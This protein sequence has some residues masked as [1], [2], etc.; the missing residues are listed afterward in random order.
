MDE[1]IRLDQRFQGF[2]DGALGGY[3]AGVVAKRI[4]GPAEVNLRSLPP[5]DRD[6]EIRESGDGLELHDGDTLILEALSAGFD[7]EVPEPPTMGEAEAAGNELVH[8][9]GTHLYP[10]CFACGPDRAEGDGL[11]LFMGRRPDRDRMLAAAWTPHPDLASDGGALPEELVWAA[12]DCP[13]IWVAWSRE[14]PAAIPTDTFTVLARQR[15]EA[16]EPVPTGET[17]IVSAWSIEQEGRKHRCGAAIHDA[18]GRLLVRAE[19]LL[20]EVPRQNQAAGSL[21]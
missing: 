21:G 1:R 10:G 14:R 6:L 12:L 20:V 18:A 4:E 13:T 3:A 15:L 2:T 17:S 8:D 19:S 11:R 7:L 5:L 16:I 9:E